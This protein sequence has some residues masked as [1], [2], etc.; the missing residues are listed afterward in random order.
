MKKIRNKIMLTMMV[1]TLLPAI[2]IG[3]YSFYTT[4]E[5]LKE[6]ALIEQ[7]NQLVN[8]QQSIQSTVSRVESDLLFLRDSNAMQLYLAAKK[9]SRQ[10]SKLL[11]A[12]L[13]HLAQQFSQQQQIYSS[14]RFL[15]AT[16]Q[17]QVRIEMRD[18]IATDLD[19]KGELV[20]RGERDYFTEAVN[21]QSNQVYISP[22]ELRK[23]KD[24][25]VEPYQSTIRY[26][27]A[28]RDAD[29]NKQGVLVLNLNADSL[30]KV[31]VGKKQDKWVITL[32]DPEGF[33]FYHPDESKQ[34]SGPSNLKKSQNI[35]DDKAF[36]LDS[37]RGSHE[38]ITSEN[39]S[40]LA[41][42]SPVVLGENRPKLGYLFNIV[43]KEKLFKPLENY[44][45]ISLIIA[46]VSLLLSLIF[47]AMLANS[48]SEP[49]VDLKDSVE[50]L[51]RGDLESPI[52]I[53]ANNEV[54]EL[55][56]AVELLRKSMN[57]L[58][59]RSGR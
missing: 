10:R 29:G 13:R 45:I 33:Y 34:W 47:A 41:L 49:L 31:L 52:K 6:N 39:E 28:V 42:S 32:T 27:T 44:L 51:S 9:S 2:L 4:S 24:K 5:A 16:G 50:R 43:S 48:L 30:V 8:A 35:F 7:R 46:A 26:S 53:K 12:N 38:I 55:S 23:V 56:R 21:L 1:L 37:V 36:K 22:L 19:K 57:I 20:N 40:M 14:V 58:M 25:V 3:A 11:L 17:E 54:G 18:E 15:D 59:K